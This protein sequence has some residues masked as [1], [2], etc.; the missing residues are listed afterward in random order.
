MDVNVTFDSSAITAPAGF[1]T[2]VE[3]VA[4]FYDSQFANPITINIDVG[5]GEI[6]GQALSA[7]DLGESESNYTT[8]TYS[9]TQIK[10][11]LDN[12]ALTS[13]A[14]GAVATLPGPDPTAGGEFAMTTAEA[15][16][17]GLMGA[18]SV[19]DGW[20]GFTSEAG[21]FDFA[22]NSNTSTSVVPESEYDFFAVVA[23]EF[24]EI[25]GRQMNF[26][27]NYGEGP[28]DGSG[29]YPLDLFDY[30]APGVRSFSQSASDRF[31]SVDGGN[32]DLD[33]FNTDSSGD[34]FDWANSAGN[35]AYD[36]FANPGVV[37]QVTTTD[38]ELMNII[39]YQPTPAFNASA[40]TISGLTL[41]F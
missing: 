17:L 15:K 3:D 27:I 26:G 8:T 1:E 28:G 29:Y 39:G 19:I 22:I 16:A 10:N 36:A 12:S 25:M 30:T 24:S 2:D 34:L 37:N 7:D 18:S 31:F 13:Q 4:K 20:A 21:T 14:Q 11:A 41:T 38:F 6:D 35:D 5:W 33:N 32:T 23:H 9:Y 40:L